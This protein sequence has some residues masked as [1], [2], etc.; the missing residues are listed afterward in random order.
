MDHVSQLR[1]EKL[2][3]SCAEVPHGRRAR[4]MAGCR[5]LLCRA[6]NS[7]YQVEIDCRLAVGDVNPLVPA[8][9]ARVLLLALRKS[10]VGYKAAA[11][12]AG[13]SRGIVLG[14]ANGKR[15]NCRLST[16]KAL[17]GVDAGARSG[18]ALVS[19]APTWRLLNEL[20]ERGYTRAWIAQQLGAKKPALQI[21]R[22][23]ITA[24]TE[25]RVRRLYNL[26]NAGKIRRAS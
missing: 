25:A 15:R 7:Q 12:A 9:P 21:H 3:A 6:A 5:C 26:L 11:D 19:A 4:Y 22:G 23:W 18:G 10:N 13:V 20:I 24:E 8:E 17:L 14:I 16:L 1:I 2:R